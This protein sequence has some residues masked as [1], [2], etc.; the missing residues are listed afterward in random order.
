[1]RSTAILLALTAAVALSACDEEV[2]TEPAGGDDLEQLEPGIHPVLVVPPRQARASAPR[3]VRSG[4]GEDPDMGEWDDP[5]ATTPDDEVRP[6]AA[7]D[8]EVVVLVHLKRVEVDADIASFQGRLSYSGNALA[9]LGGKV[10]GPAL[11]AWHEVEPGV[12]RF[13]GL[14]TEGLAT[15]EPVLELRFQLTGEQVTSELFELELE[16]VVAVDGYQELTERVVRRDRPLL[17]REAFH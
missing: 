14:V 8:Q 6:G 13:A 7:V 10:P 4:P 1:M 12:I 17:S 15:D 11:G 9:L 3:P 5:R 2:L 16:E